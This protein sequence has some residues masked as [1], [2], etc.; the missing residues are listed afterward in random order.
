MSEI[1]YAWWAGKFSGFLNG[2][3]YWDL[4]QNVRENIEHILKEWEEAH[5]ERK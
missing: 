5:K 4:P 3:K 1:N 2:L